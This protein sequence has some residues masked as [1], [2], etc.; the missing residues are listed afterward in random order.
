MYHRNPI[1][2]PT[3]AAMKYAKALG[4]KPRDLAAKIESSF[5]SSLVEKIEI[6][7]P[8]FVNFFMKKDALRIWSDA[9]GSWVLQM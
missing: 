1:R 3:N 7:G 8:G 9:F 6:A 2:A 5:S 4:L